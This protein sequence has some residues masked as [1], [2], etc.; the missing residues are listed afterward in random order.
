MCVFCVLKTPLGSVELQPAPDPVQ[1]N[2]ELISQTLK[3]GTAL[4]SLNRQLGEENRQLKREHQRIVG[5]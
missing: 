1:L 2:R 5:E 3:Q 4:G